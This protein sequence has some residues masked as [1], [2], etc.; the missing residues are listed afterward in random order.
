[1]VISKQSKD[2]FDGIPM[3]AFHGVESIL[4]MIIFLFPGHSYIV[5]V[6]VVKRKLCHSGVRSINEYGA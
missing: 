3:I 4:N 6:H 1:M 2:T 5:Y